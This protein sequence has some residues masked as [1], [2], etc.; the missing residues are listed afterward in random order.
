MT[1]KTPIWPHIL[2]VISDLDGVVYRGADPIPSA[3]QAFQRWHRAGL[4]YGF[5]TNNSTRTAA[6]FASKI[7]SMGI[8]VVPSQIVTTA[9][10]TAEVVAANHPASARVFVVG[11]AALRDAI[12]SHGFTI[13]DTAVDVVVVGLD[14][15]FSY[16]TL[17]LAQAALLAGAAFYGTNADPMLPKGTGF[18]PG[19]GSIL[20]AIAVASGKTPVIIGKPGRQMI[21]IG[22]ARL[23]T[24]RAATLMIGDQ[25]DTDIIAGK[26]AGLPTVLVN[27][28]V[29]QT[30]PRQTEPDFEVDDLTEIPHG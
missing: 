29:P 18:E 17:G 15:S 14:Q 30:G 1:G 28:G 12:L 24:P 5:V 16:Q 8:P 19:A 9:E 7:N 6:E 25:I 4:P 13:A 10:A 22:L 26:A 2:G 3:V 11:A 23:G 27:T 20:R 21:D